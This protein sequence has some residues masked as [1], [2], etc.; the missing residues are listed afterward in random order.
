VRGKRGLQL[1]AFGALVAGAYRAGRRTGEASSPS[2]DI[3]LPA[4]ED[5]QVRERERMAR[6]AIEQ[7]NAD[8]E[9]LIYTVS[10]D[11]KSPLITVLGYIDL[12]RAD[13]V[14]LPDEA[15]HYIERMEAGALYMQE[16]IND[17]LLLSR[18]GRMEMNSED[19]DLAS[20]VAEVL[21]DLQSR[22]RQA[23]ISVGSLPVVTMS[24]VRARQ[25]L[26]NLIDNALIHSGRDDVIVEVGAEPTAEGGARLWVADDGCGIQANE[27]DR[28]F[29]VF[30]RLGERPAG[31]GGTG[32]GLTV[33][34]KIMQ[35]VGGTISLADVPVG[36]TAEVVFPAHIVAWRS[37]EVG[38]T[39]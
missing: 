22:S 17:L 9:S 28:A 23:S 25:L 14:E 30:E 3:D 24:P 27:R 11:L 36:T 12:L 21:E 34:R 31:E 7:A 39:R 8:V 1:C 26:A 29:G 38:A 18:I 15:V 33:C 6:E 35:H 37:T 5:A 2:A 32:V 19:V 10:H 13:G 20:L 4:L 16:L